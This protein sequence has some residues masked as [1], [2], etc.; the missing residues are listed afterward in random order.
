MEWVAMIDG[1]FSCS[2]GALVHCDKCNANFWIGWWDGIHCH[3]CGKET[4][5]ER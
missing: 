1:V 2:D 3:C 4:E 5:N